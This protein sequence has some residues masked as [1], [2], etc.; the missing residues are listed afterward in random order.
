MARV[1]AYIQEWAG[2]CLV[3]AIAMGL[4]VGQR[5]EG[6][7]R[8][9]AEVRVYGRRFVEI[10]EAEQERISE[11]LDQRHRDNF[12]H[13]YGVEWSREEEERRNAEELEARQAY[14]DW[15]YGPQEEWQEE[16]GVVEQPAGNDGAVWIWEP[17]E[18]WGEVEASDRRRSRGC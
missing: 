7:T 16:D 10:F 4:P 13:R 15:L 11:V 6:E 3:A 12:R 14:R 2:D 5:Q 9:E 17:E 18:W 1:H 8:R